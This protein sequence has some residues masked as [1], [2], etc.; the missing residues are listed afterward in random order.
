MAS[1]EKN[2]ELI[3]LAHDLAGVPMCEDYEKMI[4][5]MLYVSILTLSSSY[6]NT[7]TN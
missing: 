1:K 2:P 7:Y 5:G 6:I 4:S 3:V